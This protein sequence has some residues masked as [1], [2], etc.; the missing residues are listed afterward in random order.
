MIKTSE[1][2]LNF[3]KETRIGGIIQGATTRYAVLIQSSR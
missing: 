2:S 1:F 3:I